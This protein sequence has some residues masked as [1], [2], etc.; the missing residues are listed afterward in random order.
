M[1]W[2]FTRDAVYVSGHPGL[3]RSTDGGTTF[4]RTNDGLP[5]TDLHAF[6]PPGPGSASLP[7]PPAAGRGRRG[8]E[9]QG[10]RSSAESSWTPP[11]TTGWSPPTPAPAPLFN[12][13][14]G[15]DADSCVFRQSAA[16]YPPYAVTAINGAMRV[17]VVEDEAQLA[18]TIARGLRREAMAVD[19]AGDGVAAL[20][21]AMVNDYDVLIL[22][23]DI[24]GIHGDD[25][26][27]RL[28]QAGTR[29]RVLMLTAAAGIT[30]RVEGLSLGADDYLTKPFAFAE[31]VA[32][33]RALARRTQPGVPPVL[34]AGDL[35]LDPA[36]QV[37]TRGERF[38]FLTRK[39]LA[40]LEVLLG[41]NGAVVS[42]ET[43]LERAWD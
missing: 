36:R 3:N 17:L 25:V 6:T 42:T 8:R 37:V 20:D 16:L 1:G 21:R 29:A 41:A 18:E 14:A 40:V 33:V 10:S 26:C 43:L 31:L 7:R 38:L 22:D 15:R 11:T 35:V 27:R 13:D 23:R 32:R 2:A 4:A 34:R 28:A 12:A 39:E 30:D 9:R 19:V 24:P 5:D